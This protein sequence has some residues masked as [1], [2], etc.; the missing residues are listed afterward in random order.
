MRDQEEREM[1]IKNK[2]VERQRRKGREGQGERGSGRGGREEDDIRH[3][4]GR[5]KRTG[6][7]TCNR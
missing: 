3:G 6:E 7:E 1:N 4:A 5:K 2:G